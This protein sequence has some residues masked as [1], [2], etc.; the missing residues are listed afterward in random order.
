MNDYLSVDGSSASSI[1]L[2]AP[3]GADEKS[4]AVLLDQQ[5][6]RF[7]SGASTSIRV[8]TAHRLLAG[9]LMTIG[10][11]IQLHPETDFTCLSAQSLYAKG[12]MDLSAQIRKGRLLLAQA[13][14]YPLK[15]ENVALMDTLNAIPD[16]FQQYRPEFF[17]Q[18]IPC[19][20]DYP[21]CH[22]VKEP[23]AGIL[24]INEYLRRLNMEQAFLRRFQGDEL[25][26]LLSVYCGD[27]RELVL[28]L[29]TPVAESVV[30][31]AMAGLDPKT[32][33]MEPSC[34]LI[35]EKRLG[36]LDEPSLSCQLAKAVRTVCEKVPVG[37]KGEQAY[38]H[39]AA[40]DLLP[41]MEAALGSHNLKRIFFPLSL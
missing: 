31:R 14:A 24:F 25:A 21:L 29:Y 8:E 23:S 12:F 28:N 20:I 7:Q 9:I 41:R 33:G 2:Y 15:V 13:R 38:L 5:I 17:P 1:E 10:T 26:A 11:A 32:L 6:Q 40:Q 18:D 30:G 19:S 22:P 36:A 34:L 35:L 37:G 39:E 16:F 4:I 27:Y 3:M